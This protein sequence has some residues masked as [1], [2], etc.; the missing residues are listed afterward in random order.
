M[1]LVKKKPQRKKDN[2]IDHTFCFLKIAKEVVDAIWAIINEPFCQL[3]EDQI[4][5]ALANM[6][7]EGSELA[8]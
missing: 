2:E 4:N 6:G 1:N 8:V 7:G 5:Q 3:I